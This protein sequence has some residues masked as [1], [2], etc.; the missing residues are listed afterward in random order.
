MKTIKKLSAMLLSAAMLFTTTACNSKNA[1]LLDTF[2]NFDID[3]Y[4]TIGDYK[5]LTIYVDDPT[6]TEDEINAEINKLI[7]K[8]ATIQPITDR[9]IVQAGD[10]ANINYVGY[11]DDSEE[12]Q[13]NM[14]DESESGHDLE[15][16]S[17]S[18][19]PGFEDGLIGVAVG[20]KVTLNLTFPSDYGN[21]SMR[22]KKARF[23]VTVNALNEIIKPELNDEFVTANTDYKTVDEY[24]KGLAE[25]ITKSNQKKLDD[26][27]NDSVWNKAVDN[28][29]FHKYPEDLLENYKKESEDYI[30]MIASQVY[31]MT[32]DEYIETVGETKESFKKIIEDRA[33]SIIKSELA[34]LALA[35]RENI[36]VTQKIYEEKAESYIKQFKVEDL[37]ELESKYNKKDICIDIAYAQLLEIIVKDSKSVI[38]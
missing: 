35:K 7:L 23:E 37:D 33:I 26:S 27:F 14:T 22:N 30:T 19:I 21:P 6:A 10:V 25:S 36:K 18:F 15:I 12:P 28:C 4:I 5:N 20:E 17:K 8:K 24:K 13:K 2:Y 3:E 16:G 11:L 38:K 31:G 32:L 29:T 34:I 1:D 9:N